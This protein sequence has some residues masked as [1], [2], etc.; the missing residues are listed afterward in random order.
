MHDLCQSPRRYAGRIDSNIYRDN[1]AWPVVSRD[2][3]VVEAF[4]ENRSRFTI[5][6]QAIMA[7]CLL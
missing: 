7:M 2:S 3:V 5:R 1:F 4:L 6:A